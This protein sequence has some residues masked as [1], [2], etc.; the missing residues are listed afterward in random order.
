MAIKFVTKPS[1]HGV[2]IANKNRY[3]TMAQINGLFSFT[4][5][6]GKATFNEKFIQI[7]LS[8]C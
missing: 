7:V 4:L 3:S 8:V 5:S 1:I 2:K 6:Q